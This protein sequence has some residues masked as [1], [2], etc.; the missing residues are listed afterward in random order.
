MVATL[1]LQI[2]YQSAEV[3]LHPTYR[4][5]EVG[6]PY[7]FV[8]TV[9]RWSHRHLVYQLEGDQR[10]PGAVRRATCL[11]PP[12]L[13]HGLVGVAEVDFEGE[14]DAVYGKDVIEQEHHSSDIDASLGFDNIA[15]N[16][17]PN[18]PHF[19]CKEKQ[20]EIR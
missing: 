3:T 9:S 12:Q 15:P 10:R 19:T 17:I 2:L 11:R 20:P 5:I 4:R 18:V 7:H 14:N 8:A 16:T 13:E 6:E 1:W